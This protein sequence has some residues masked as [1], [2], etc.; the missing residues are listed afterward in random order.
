M[1]QL[2][3]YLCVTNPVSFSMRKMGSSSSAWWLGRFQIL[4]RKAVQTI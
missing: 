4:V 1:Q 2:S 3:M